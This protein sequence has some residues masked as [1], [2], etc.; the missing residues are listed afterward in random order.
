[1]QHILIADDHLPVR[2]GLKALVEDVLGK[3][4]ID[5][6][7][8]GTDLFEKLESNTYEVLITD[9]NM[10]GVNIV[11]FISDVLAICPKLRI[12]VLSINPE[13]VF[14]RRMLAAG[15]YGY[16]QKDAADE[17][18]IQAIRSIGSGLKYLSG[19]QLQ[20]IDLLAGGGP[21]NANPFEKLSPREMEVTLLLL[22]GYGPLE[23]SNT[24]VI[25][26]STASSLKARVFE[27]LNISN[28]VALTELARLHGLVQG[29]PTGLR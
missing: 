10:P 28:L 21:G 12:L 22:R 3:C 4:R 11:S 20:D 2:F 26:S 16:L 19:R 29:F 14:A 17:E 5:F 8:N 13:D 25:S 23:V 6:A 24:L 1:M 9:L 15:A 18:M 27:K 7:V